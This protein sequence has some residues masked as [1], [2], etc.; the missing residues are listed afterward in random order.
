MNIVYIPA[1]S[2]VWVNVITELEKLKFYPKIWLGDP[3][4]DEFAKKKYPDCMVLNFHFVHKNIYLRCKDFTVDPKIFEDKYFF[5]LK[6]QVYKMMDRQDDLGIYSRLD[7]EAFFYSTF[8]FFYDKIVEDKIKLAIVAEGPHSPVTMIIYGICHILN[9]PSYYLSQNLVVPS[10]H[11][12]KDLYG[13]KLRISDHFESFKY[14]VHL[15]IAEEYIDSISDKIPKPLYIQIQ[16]DK[17]KLSIIEDTKNYL[18]KPFLKSIGY[19]NTNQ[20][21]SINRHDFFDSNRPSFSHNLKTILKKKKLLVKYNKIVQDVSLED[22]FVFVPL[23]YEPERTSNPDGGHYYNVYDMLVS[24]RSYVPSNIKIIIKE[25]PL[26]FAKTLHGHRGR[27]ALFY[28]SISMLPNIQFAKLDVSSDI[29][30]KKS[31]LVATQTGTAALE[32]SI[33]EKKS[34]VFGSPWFLGV[35][36]VYAYGDFSFEELLKKHLFSKTEVKEYILDY[37]ANY[38]LPVCVNPSGL[39]YFKRKYPEYLNDLLND[40]FFAE[41]FAL[42]IF[43]DLSL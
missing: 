37:I 43:N 2:N 3:K 22:E 36:N 40:E 5:T 23:H 4:H 8:C 25:H 26:Q 28:Q 34:L 13:R 38:T 11:I 6:D 12:S 32:A 14:D 19:G 18:V 17:N 1:G 31:I 30:I 24:L 39:E 7:R 20:S 15:K 16:N 27:S 21:Y 33:L 35:P 41:Q 29:L 9:I 42:A 10:A